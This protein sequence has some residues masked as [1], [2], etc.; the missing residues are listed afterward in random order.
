MKYFSLQK[1]RYK[2]VSLVIANNFL[3]F[4]SIIVI[5]K[6]SSSHLSK[7]QYGFYAL[8]LSVY[9]LISIL[10]FLSLHSAIERYLIEYKEEGKLKSNY[11][12]I[13]SIH[14]LFFLIYLLLLPFVNLILPNNWK[15][16]SL[17]LL[18][19]I[20]T[21]V[22]RTLFIVTLNSQKKR[23][24]LLLIRTIDFITQLII[25]LYFVY[26][27]SFDVILF[28][29]SSII[30]SL[31]TILLSIFYE[32]E[33][34]RIKYFNVNKFKEILSIVVNFSLP[35]LF[36]G[37]FIWL[38]NMICRWY[39]DVLLTKVDVAN[40]SLMVALALTPS[41]AFIAVVSNMYVPIAYANEKSNP[42]YI[43]DTNKAL[44]KYSILF[45]IIVIL[46]FILFND[47]IV[48]ILL[49][50][51]YIDVS[52]SLPYLVVGA[53]IYAIGQVSI[54][55]VYYYK[56][57]KMLVLSN[58]LPGLFTVIFGFVFI[59]YFQFEG[60]VICTMISYVISGV[61]TLSVSNKFTKSNIY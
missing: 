26:Y 13:L 40:Y 23:L 15:N 8:I 47:F 6:L 14:L 16:I 1:K 10:P 43:S 7:E 12:Y 30:S 3:E 52:W 11:I 42:G 46:F 20:L 25:I 54:Y 33:N 18:L 51:K 17:L 50:E 45:W 53:A 32:R 48:R 2:E 5:T 55:E 59:K 35:F 36:W 31:L 57:A 56:K 27:G 39:L 4:F 60:A 61:I 24:A 58:I 19:F 9:G 29:C 22:Y 21:K 34:I 44:K 37:V 41:S 28:I 38:Q 49:D